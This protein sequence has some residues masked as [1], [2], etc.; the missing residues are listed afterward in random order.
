MFK[1]A[2]RTYSDKEFQSLGAGAYEL[3]SGLA[4]S[5]DFGL[6][7][8][9]MSTATG[10]T[11]QQDAPEKF[12]IG[13]M[14]LRQAKE[15]FG[16]YPGDDE[17]SDYIKSL[18]A[19]AGA[20]EKFDV[21]KYGSF[22]EK[23]IGRFGLTEKDVR[24]LASD[25]LASQKI[26][27]IVGSGLAVDRNAVAQN[28]ALD[29]QQI[30]GEI[31]RL[32]LAPLEEKIQPTE[33]EIKTYWDVI[34]DAFTTDPLRKFT[35]VI[36]SPSLPAEPE[37]KKETPPSIADA[38]ASPEAKA[39]ADKKKEEEK[40][41]RAA[42]F[43]EQR[44]KKQLE[45]DTLVSNFYD[46]LANKKGA[47]FEELAKA[48]GWE[49]KTSELFAKATPPKE[50]DID[51][52]ASSSGGKATEILFQIQ[53]T[54][55][56]FSKISPAIAIG[57]NQW[58]IARIDGEEKSR[59]K[60][61]EEARADARAQYISEKAV[62]ALKTAANEAVSKIKAAITS[63]KSFA[64]AAKEAGVS[65]LKPFTSIISTYRPD[66][67]TEPQN[68]FQAARNVDPG[69]LADAIIESDRAFIVYVSKREVVKAADAA[70]RLDSEVKNLSTQ[71]ETFAFSS[72]LSARVEAAKVETLY[73][74]R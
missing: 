72:W 61:Y 54:K 1:I 68:L 62:E 43:A 29:N 57:E 14:I 45:T 59:P 35:Y 69:S 26:N 56:P 33:E 70:T 3:T 37:A 24:E 34:K 9:L 71:N 46:E 32:A 74:Q 16:V 30:T 22:I 18:R 66:T 12:F 67:A 53:E 52:R 28:L 41:K 40:A 10:A 65:E 6:Y 23:G 36:I 73:K 63:G 2:D 11:S 48:N 21:E 49:V 60:T 42:D 47:A 13:R 25:V 31:G 64:D 50:L 51:L 19:F 15:E 55:D 27:S 44:R 38:A 39:A 20:D 4:R 7:Q 58:L 5:G 17:I 8:F